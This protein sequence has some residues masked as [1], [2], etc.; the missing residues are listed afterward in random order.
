MTARSRP[1]RRARR[2]AAG[3]AVSLLALGGAFAALGSASAATSASQQW[4][5]SV[6]PAATPGVGQTM[7]AGFGDTGVTATIQVVS[8]TNTTCS[9]PAPAGTLGGTNAT[10]FLEPDPPAGSA[11]V[12]QCTG[13]GSAFTQVVTFSKPVL[14]PILHVD[15]LDGSLASV[16]GTTTTGAPVTLTTLAKNN[17]LEVSP[18]GNST[19]LNSTPQVARNAGCQADDGTN[20]TA[21][22]GSFVLGGG[23]VKS[24]TLY[25]Q[26]GN[27]TGGDAWAWSLSF[28]TVKLTKAFEPGKI[29]AGETGE[30]NFFITNPVDNQQPT[31]SPLDFT[32]ALPAGVT[33]ADSTFGTNS[34]CG[35]P[36]VTD[37][38]GGSLDAGDTGVKA[39][40]LTVSP[41]TTCI[42]TVHVTSD[43]P[44]SY[45]NDNSNLSTGVANLVPD[46]STVLVVDTP[47]I[48]GSAAAAALVLGGGGW[49]FS[50]RSRVTRQ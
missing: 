29:Q 41:G 2:V 3:A 11:A 46:T 25:N 22:C 48:A 23:P 9:W 17:A 15:N 21:G 38:A 14:S 42:L 49:L 47:M 35:T 30:L 1:R 24:F 18:S 12:Q 10:D 20:P 37:A 4:M 32:D 31:L 43:T 27:V 40:N 16:G 45:T 44:G 8:G 19:V 6:S 36:A 50:R 28:P 33:I 39:A 34:Q 13:Q 26:M 7:T 5:T